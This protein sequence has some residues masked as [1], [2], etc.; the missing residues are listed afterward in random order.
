[1]KA[2]FVITALALIAAPF[3]QTFANDGATLFRNNCGACHTVG[4]GKLVGPDLKDVQN[5]HQES[6][7]LKW[8]KSS[9]TLVQAG[10]K[11]AVKLFTDNSSIP[12]PD[13]GISENEI[14]SILVYIN[15]AGD[16]PVAATT[17]AAPSNADAKTSIATPQVQGS[18][19]SVIKLFKLSI[20][21]YALI[22]LFGLLLIVIW[23]MGN[24]IKALSGKG[25]GEKLK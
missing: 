8:I 20:A 22:A 19:Y 23:I 1:M 15:A 12:M 14:K 9:Q 21:Q 6:W 16:Q 10:D 11:D 4:N 7:L 24:A 13:Q 17:A 25:E 5:R 3:T 2:R 18:T